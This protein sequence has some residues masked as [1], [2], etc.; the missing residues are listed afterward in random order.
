MTILSKEFKPDNSEPHN[1]LK[2]SFTNIGGLR[3]N[4]V[5]YE[6]FLESNSHD[7]LALCET[8]LDDSVDSG[9]LYVRGYLPLIQ[10][11]VWF[12]SLRERRT[13]FCTGLISRTLRI[14]DY[15]FDWLYFTQCL[16]SFLQLYQKAFDTVDHDILTKKLE[17]FGIRGVAK[18]WFI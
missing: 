8:N 6:F 13:S 2:L 4:F 1:S 18:D 3:S 16:T 5:E 17:H 15:V 10:K 7:I 12:C 14:L 11:Y 9:K